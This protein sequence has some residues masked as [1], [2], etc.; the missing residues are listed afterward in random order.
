ML[1]SG[2]NVSGTSF[3]YIVRHFAF[4][5]R[6]PNTEAQAKKVR[7]A[8]PDDITQTIVAAVAATH[9]E[10]RRTGWQIDF[11]MCDQELTDL[12]AIVVEHAANR[13]ATEIHVA[14]WLD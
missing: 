7:T 1:Y 12:Q 6:M 3:Q 4:L 2:L 14:L 9:F 11:V 8:V 10:A 13:A 5:A